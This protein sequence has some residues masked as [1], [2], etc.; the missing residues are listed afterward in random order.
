[1]KSRDITGVTGVPEL[2]WCYNHNTYL[3]PPCLPPV[4]RWRTDSSIY[5][6]LFHIPAPTSAHISNLHLHLM[7]FT[8]PIID[9]HQ[10][11][12]TANRCNHPAPLLP[13]NCWDHN[14]RL[15][16]MIIASIPK[17]TTN[18]ILLLMPNYLISNPLSDG[19]KSLLLQHHCLIILVILYFSKIPLSP[20]PLSTLLTLTTITVH[21]EK[22][23]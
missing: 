22:N 13:C 15:I 18:F 21:G 6:I 12:H 11:C 10:T 14:G 5:R 23:V 19:P 9:F 7:L 2:T 17:T 20:M 8:A 3:L 16:Q 1:M 4:Q